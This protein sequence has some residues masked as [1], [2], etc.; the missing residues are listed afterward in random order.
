MKNLFTTCALLAIIAFNAPFAYA[1]EQAPDALLRTV[2]S[3]VV[4]I[5]KQ[6]RDIQAGNSAKATAL[7]ETRILPLFDFSRM[8]RIAVARNWRL[9]TA[10]QQDSLTREFKTLL[11]RTY[12]TALT[13]YR[14]QAIEFKR[15]RA[16]PSDNEVTVKSEIKQP[17]TDALAMDYDMEKTA[18]GWKVYDIKIDGVSLVANYRETFAARVREGGIDGLIN[19]LAAKNRQGD[20]RHKAPLTQSYEN[21]PLVYASVQSFWPE[22]R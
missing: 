10:E 4:A 15:L 13:N 16:M 1:Q 8:T 11:V 14:D 12:S 22:G 7:V 17:G 9:A 5:L 20:S 6:N 3:D 2:T 18:A 19:V 21:I